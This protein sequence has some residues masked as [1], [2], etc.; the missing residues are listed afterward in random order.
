[1]GQQ[2]ALVPAEMSGCEK[3]PVSPR[4]AAFVHLGIR[5]GKDLNTT[6][7]SLLPF[8]EALGF[9]GMK[10]MGRTFTLSFTASALLRGTV[11]NSR[12][13]PSDNICYCGSCCRC[14]VVFLFASRKARLCPHSEICEVLW[15]IRQGNHGS[16]TY[17]RAWG[18]SFS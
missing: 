12:G 3:T 9:R 13:A 18:A 6:P 11:L 4:H 15:K 1:M 16:V 14:G 10:N 5:T 17:A 7:A 2:G 8:A